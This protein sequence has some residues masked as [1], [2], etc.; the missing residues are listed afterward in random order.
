MYFAQQT[1]QFSEANKDAFFP[2]MEK[3]NLKSLILMCNVT[4][5]S[6]AVEL[7][8][9]DY[10]SIKGYGTYLQRDELYLDIPFHFHKCIA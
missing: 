10:K 8:G 7:C 5:L 2:Q 4:P 9:R 6:I 3:S 1:T